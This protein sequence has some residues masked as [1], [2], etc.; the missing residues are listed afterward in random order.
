MD[1]RS[2]IYRVSLERLYKMDYYNKVE[3]FI[4]YA[5]SNPRNIIRG[6][7]TYSYKRCKDK[8]K[9]LNLDVITM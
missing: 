6:G 8:K 4:N 2:W 3:S 7:I 9:F 1:D 5:L